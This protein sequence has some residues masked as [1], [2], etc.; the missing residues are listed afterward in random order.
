MEKVKQV[1]VPSLFSAGASLIIYKY[2]LGEELSEPVPFMG[3][4]SYPAYIVV[5]ASSMVGS[6]SGELLSD[7]VIPKIPVIES[8]K[9]V[10]EFLLPPS[11]TGLTTYGALRVLV[12]EETSFKNGFLLG[13]GS[14]VLGKYAYNMI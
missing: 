2:L 10:Q 14:S 9:S 13:A 4:M 3:S 8:L 6:I 7:V 5:G 11:I 1:L 12:S